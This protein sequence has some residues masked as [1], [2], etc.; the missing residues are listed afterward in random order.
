M[1]KG[2][3]FSDLF[4]LRLITAPFCAAYTIYRPF[5]LKGYPILFL[6]NCT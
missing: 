3:G 1:G 5:Y 6:D 4:T 2:A